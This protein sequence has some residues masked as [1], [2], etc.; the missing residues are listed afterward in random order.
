MLIFFVPIKNRIF[1]NRTVES[2]WPNLTKMSMVSSV[3]VDVRLVMKSVKF[4]NPSTPII[5]FLD[6]VEG[7]F[8]HLD[9]RKWLLYQS[10]MF[11]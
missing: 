6:V 11:V 5:Q 8:R 3:Y 7:E 4:V 10:Y 9:C 1:V 2:D